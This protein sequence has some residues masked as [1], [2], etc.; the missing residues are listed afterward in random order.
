MGE[1]FAKSKSVGL[2]NTVTDLSDSRYVRAGA[3]GE[4]NATTLEA[5]AIHEMAHGLIQPSQLSKWVTA[6]SFWTDAYNESGEIGTEEPPTQYGHTNAA[7]DLCESAA[8]YFV[9]RAHLLSVAPLRAAFLD[10]MVAGWT[11]PVKAAVVKKTLAASGAG[12]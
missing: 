9:N 4:D 10:A 1:Y 3:T 12:T 5:N 2:F 8:I 6:L 11:P 7:E